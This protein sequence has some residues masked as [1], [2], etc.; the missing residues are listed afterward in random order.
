[1]QGE[2][3]SVFVGTLVLYGGADKFA[4]GY[5]AQK[6]QYVDMIKAGIVD[7]L[8]VV[9]TALVDVIGVASLLTTSGRVWLMFLRIHLLVV[10]VAGWVG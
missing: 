6:G 8:K 3:A 9:Q 1:M 7:P 5:N 2:E 10:P 4:W